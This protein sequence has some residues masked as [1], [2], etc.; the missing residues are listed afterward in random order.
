MKSLMAEETEAE[1]MTWW[2]SFCL[3]TKRATPMIATMI[4][5]QMV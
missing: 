5:F 2:E 4:L 1:Q 3:V